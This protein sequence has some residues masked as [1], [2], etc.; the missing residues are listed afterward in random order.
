MKVGF[1]GLGTMGAS[2]ASNLQAGGHELQVSDVRKEAAAPHLKAG[3]IWKDTPRQVAEGVEAVFTSL[4]GPKEVEQVAL[5][6]EGLIH[7]MKK[8]SAYFDLSTNS[9]ALMRRLYPAFKEKGIHVL[10]APVSGGP[11]GAKSRKLALWIGGDRDVY[12]RFKPVLDA[13]GDQPYYV[14]PIGAGSVAKLVHNCAGYAVQTA[15]AEVFTMG[16]KAGVDP[17]SLWKAVRQ[18][19]GG[20]KRPGRN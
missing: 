15:L 14:G 5:G 10:D 20:S 16:V 4:P 11:K 6:P 18:G 19:A 12:D 13:I 8:G 17:L 9:P 2:M 7:G 3:A 1:I